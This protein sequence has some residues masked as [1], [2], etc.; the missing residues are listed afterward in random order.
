MA[1]ENMFGIREHNG[2]EESRP[3]TRQEG[4]EQQVS[5]DCFLLTLA[6]SSGSPLQRLRG[7]EGATASAL[8]G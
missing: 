3:K 5:F 8:R 4:K 1:M 6:K 7:G 2:E